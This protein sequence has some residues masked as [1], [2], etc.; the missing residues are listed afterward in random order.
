[1]ASQISSY[2]VIPVSSIS[3]SIGLLLWP[4]SFHSPPGV[5]F[6]AACVGYFCLVKNTAKSS[7]PLRFTLSFMLIMLVH[8]KILLFVPIIF[9][10]QNLRIGSNFL[11]GSPCFFAYMDPLNRVRF[12]SICKFN[13]FVV[14]E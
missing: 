14:N 1:M 9:F 4:V 10:L 11:V 3:V 6:R 13:M 5:Q 8:S 2:Q 12:I 7:P